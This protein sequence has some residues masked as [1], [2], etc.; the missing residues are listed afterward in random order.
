MSAIYDF[1]DYSSNT[2]LLKETL[3]GVLLKKELKYPA[4]L[5]KCETCSSTTKFIL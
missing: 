4:A 2:L 3:N 5:Y 1:P